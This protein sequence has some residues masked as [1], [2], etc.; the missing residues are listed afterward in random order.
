M[1]QVGYGHVDVGLY[2]RRLYLK[3]WVAMNFNFGKV[4]AGSYGEN[5]LIINGTP[6]EPVSFD[7]D[8][9]TG[10]VCDA[11]VATGVGA[12]IVGEDLIIS[13]SS[14]VDIGGHLPNGD[15]GG[16]QPA[17]HRLDGGTYE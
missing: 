5:H 10:D 15:A 9:A 3:E 11:I 4:W 16:G 14:S 7:D 2:G 1:V 13:H 6:V 17:I 12:E 8:D